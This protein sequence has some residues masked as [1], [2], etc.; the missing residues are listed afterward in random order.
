MEI[1]EKPTTTFLRNTGK[2][3]W[4]Q[5]ETLKILSKISKRFSIHENEYLNSGH[6]SIHLE[7]LYS[8]HKIVNH[9]T[10]DSCVIDYLEFFPGKNHGS[11]K[12]A[13]LISFQT[14]LP[15]IF[16]NSPF[17]LEYEFS[18]EEDGHLLRTTVK[19]KSGDLLDEIDVLAIY[20]NIKVLFDCTLQFINCP[21]SV[22]ED[23]KTYKNSSLIS[24]F[25]E[26]LL[27]Y[28]MLLDYSSNIKKVEQNYASYLLSYI[29]VQPELLEKILRKASG[30]Y[31]RFL[32]YCVRQ[33]EQ[34]EDFSQNYFSRWK[35]MNLE[36][37]LLAILCI[38]YPEEMHLDFCEDSSL[39]NTTFA[40]RDLNTMLLAR[41]DVNALGLPVMAFKRY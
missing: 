23:F 26:D 24:A 41:K 39:V 27:N 37:L 33:I 15:L 3:S 25:F 14:W 34:Q 30:G 22:G 12:Q 29:T 32:T 9:F 11:K 13:K 5:Q 2:K 31:S 36:K 38:K 6:K 8:T 1:V 35:T 40:K 19:R 16:K 21:S 4:Y 28:N 7:L 10:P 17:I 20:N 18:K